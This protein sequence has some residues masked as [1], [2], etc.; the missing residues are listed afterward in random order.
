MNGHGP[1]GDVNSNISLCGYTWFNGCTRRCSMTMRWRHRRCYCWRMRLLTKWRPC[2]NNQLHFES[3]T[4]TIMRSDQW[5]A[6]RSWPFELC[7]TAQLGSI[8]RIQI[9][10]SYCSSRQCWGSVPMSRTPEVIS[11]WPRSSLSTWDPIVVSIFLDKTF[12][13]ISGKNSLKLQ[14]YCKAETGGRVRRSEAFRSH[15]PGVLYNAVL[16]FSNLR[17]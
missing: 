9:F 4:W 13:V 1:V 11:R 14:V 7:N 12:T 6:S 15:V 3:S 10:P 16:N 8:F 2:G 5:T 17:P